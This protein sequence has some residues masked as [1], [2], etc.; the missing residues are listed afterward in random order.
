M[1]DEA[2]RVAPG[3][4]ALVGSGE[5]T[6]AMNETDGYLLETIGGA[7]AARV[8]VLPTASGLEPGSPQRWNTMGVAHFQALGVADVRSSMSV[9]RASAA[10]EEQLARLRDADLYYFSGGNPQYVV[11]TLRGT[12]AWEIIAQAHASGA[13]LAGCSAGAMM[14]GGKTMSLRVAMTGLIEWKEALGVVPRCIVFPHFDRMPGFL[15]APVVRRLLGG[16]PAGC[17]GLGIDEDTAL[18]RVAPPDAAG[19]ARWRVMGRQAVTV[20]EGTAPS[21]VLRSG[22]E[23]TI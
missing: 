7:H 11:E 15:T 12:P 23:I 20:F 13:V 18:V 19:S 2:A 5:Y 4:V 6:D 16:I 17:V 22:A 8:V 21:K 1:T 9:D 14:L 10:A 3:A